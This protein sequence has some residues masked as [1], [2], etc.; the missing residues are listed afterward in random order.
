M[1]AADPGP[2]NMSDEFAQEPLSEPPS[3]SSLSGP[4]VKVGDASENMKPGAVESSPRSPEFQVS[5]DCW[6]L[7]QTRIGP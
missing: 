7:A 6:V 4:S 1:T 5:S 3:C 2:P